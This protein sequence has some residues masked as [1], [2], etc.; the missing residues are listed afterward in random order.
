MYFSK[1]DKIEI[2]VTRYDNKFAEEEKTKIDILK[3]TNVKYKYD[4]GRKLIKN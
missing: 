2:E 1:K 4:C 3:N